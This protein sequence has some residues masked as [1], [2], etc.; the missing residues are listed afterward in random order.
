LNKDISFIILTYNEEVHLPRLLNSIAAL[1]APVYILDSGSTDNTLRI[2]EEYNAGVLV[3]PFENHPKQW[4]YALRNFAIKT[5]WVICLDAD[6]VV[7]PELM[8]ILSG[9]RDEDN[10]AIDGIYFNRKNYFKGRWIKHGG[11]YPVYLLKMFRYGKGYSDLNEN[12]DHRFIVPGNTIVWKNGHIVEENLKE[13][14]IRF[15]IEKH[16]RYS[17]LAAQEE[18]ERMRKIRQQVIEPNF[19]GSPD[20]RI[21][22]LKQI[23]WQLPLYVRPMLYFIYRFIFRLG[24]LDGREG[25]IFHFLQGYWFRLMVDIKIDEILNADNSRKPNKA[26]AA[27]LRFVFKFLVLFLLFYFFNIIF[28]GLTSPGNRY[29]AFLDHNLNYIQGLRQLL[30]DSSA[31][32]I[33]LFGFTAITD[34]YELLVAGHGILRLVYSCLGL[35]VISFFAAFVLAYPKPRKR[36]LLFLVSGII[37][38]ELLNI[39]RFVLLA[40][41]WDKRSPQIID[42]H[43]IFNVCIY[44]IITIS[45]YFWVKIPDKTEH[46]TN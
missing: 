24:V 17:D 14:N 25:R 7:T 16:N 18:V 32:V 5:P 37:V 27:A 15:W 13:N 35:G 31:A 9:F 12:L 30:L 41:F 20:E 21:A 23:W 3:H 45:L 1:E 44:I 2:A 43:T 6:Q 10:P 4:D 19:W 36:K 33:N 46:V 26:A 38:I 39:V 34:K 28:F 22:R 42:H 29:S 8:P 40:I 11:Y